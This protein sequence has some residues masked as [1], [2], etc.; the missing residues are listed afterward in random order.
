MPSCIRSLCGIGVA[1]IVVVFV[2]FLFTGYIYTTPWTF[3]TY[4]IR[5]ISCA[6]GVTVARLLCKPHHYFVITGIV[7][8]YV[9]IDTRRVTRYSPEAR[10]MAM[11]THSTS[12][13]LRGPEFPG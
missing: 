4:Y 13:L 6:L 11:A 5:V 3:R 9:V 2:E 8:I 10:S 12:Y 7:L 1:L